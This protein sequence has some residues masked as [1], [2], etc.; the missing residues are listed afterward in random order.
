MKAFDGTLSLGDLTLYPNLEALTHYATRLDRHGLLSPELRKSLSIEPDE[1]R[2]TGGISE[3]G[4]FELLQR[5]A[6]EIYIAKGWTMLTHR[7][8]PADGIILHMKKLMDRL[9]SLLWPWY[10]E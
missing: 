6:G 3:C 2:Q 1:L 10:R 9:P 4:W 7:R 8:E 5:T